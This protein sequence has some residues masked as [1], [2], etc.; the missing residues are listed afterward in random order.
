MRE[1]DAARISAGCADQQHVEASYVDAHG[2]LRTVLEWIWVGAKSRTA[3]LRPGPIGQ[4]MSD[5]SPQNQDWRTGLHDELRNT[6]T[7]DLRGCRQLR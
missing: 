3:Y 2:G 1:L 5:L 6:A 4:A 7:P